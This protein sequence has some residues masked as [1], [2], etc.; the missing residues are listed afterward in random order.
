[1]DAQELARELSH[2]GAQ[3]L[4]D[5]TAAHLAYNGPDGFPRVIPVG[6][7]WNGQ[8]IVV[9]TATTSPKVAALAARPNVAVAI[10]SGDSPGGA[11]S[12]LVRGVASVEIVDGV[13]EEY[14]AMSRK[15]ME[16]DQQAE[17]EREVRRVYPQMARISVQPRWGRF[18][19]YGAGR[20]PSFLDKIING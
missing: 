17:F 18:F 12:L 1:M 14:I 20:L 7:L 6:F 16:P 9:C 19:D 10:D 5:R 13:A 3:E 4:L 8:C 15:S 11:K 2:P